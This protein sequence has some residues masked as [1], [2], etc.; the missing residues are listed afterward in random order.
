[1]TT[2]FLHGQESSGSG[3]KGRWFR[4]HFPTV[5]VPDFSGSLEERLM[6]LQELL[7][8]CRDLVL[9]GSSFGGLMAAVLALDRPDRLHRIVLLAPALNFPEFR[10]YTGMTSEVETHLFVGRHDTICPPET[11][12]PWRSR[13]SPTSLSAFWTM[14]ILCPGRSPVWTGRDCWRADYHFS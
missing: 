12:V 14:T 10:R 6:D 13:R 2:L 8:G 5:F 3:R 4:Q 11:V 1:M 7:K 9:V